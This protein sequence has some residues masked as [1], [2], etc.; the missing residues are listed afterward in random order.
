LAVRGLVIVLAFSGSCAAALGPVEPLSTAELDQP[1]PARPSLMVP[2]SDA[3]ADPGEDMTVH[4]SS[5]E[6]IERDYGAFSYPRE[7]IWAPATR[8]RS[9]D[10]ELARQI[11]DALAG[12]RW[13]AGL[14]WDDGRARGAVWTGG[15]L[16]AMFYDEGPI[17]AVFAPGV[18]NPAAMPDH[19]WRL[20]VDEG[21]FVLSDGRLLFTAKHP[22]AQRV[23]ALGN[24]E[25]LELP[26]RSA[27]MI[28]DHAEGIDVVAKIDL[29]EP[30]IDTHD[31]I[32]GVVDGKHPRTSDPWLVGLRVDGRPFFNVELVD[33]GSARLGRLDLSA[34]GPCITAWPNRQELVRCFWLDG[35]PRS[36]GA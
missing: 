9:G 12:L 26:R 27:V 10:R 5:D 14:K 24:E 1:I 4:R 36:E 32:W 25:P 7:P 22:F 15:R 35:R 34:D 6:T 30:R 2:F 31:R 13:G 20:Q 17:I 8:D 21:P 23:D 3:D 28:F 29:H 11:E 19:A 33:F 16:I 18:P